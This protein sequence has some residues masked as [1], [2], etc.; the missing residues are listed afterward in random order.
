MPPGR[1]YVKIKEGLFFFSSGV[2]E[3]LLGGVLRVLRGLCEDFYISPCA[4]VALRPG[5]V[6]TILCYASENVLSVGLDLFV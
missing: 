4:L 5:C 2:E 3:L 1:A 6:P